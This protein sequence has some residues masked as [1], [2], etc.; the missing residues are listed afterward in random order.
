M[1]FG[2]SSTQG[3]GVDASVPGAAAAAPRASVKKQLLGGYGAGYFAGYGC[4]CY[5]PTR[6]SIWRPACGVHRMCEQA[7]LS[8]WPSFFF[9]TRPRFVAGYVLMGTGGMLTFMPGAGPCECF[10]VLVFWCLDRLDRGCGFI[11]N[12]ISRPILYVYIL[13]SVFLMIV[14]ADQRI[15]TALV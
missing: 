4:S 3:D 5:Y 8:R 10:G 11:L 14:N 7:G 6:A 9:N 2:V 12:Y 13:W 15:Y 1:L